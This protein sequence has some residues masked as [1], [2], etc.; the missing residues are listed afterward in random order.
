ME[1]F[2]EFYQDHTEVFKAIL[3]NR[4]RR[5]V[6]LYPENCGSVL[7]VS[8]FSGSEGVRYPLKL[9]NNAW[10][11]HRLSGYTV[12]SRHHLHLVISRKVREGTLIY[13]AATER[14]DIYA[15]TTKLRRA[16][17]FQTLLLN[18]CNDLSNAY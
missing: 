16:A 18:A 4:K 13:I 15:S 2:F 11:N 10:K 1:T 14:I 5:G 12:E 7:G 17:S 3:R 6:C 9:T 8:S